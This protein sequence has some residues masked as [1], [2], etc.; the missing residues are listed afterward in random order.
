VAPHLAGGADH[1]N[2]VWAALMFQLWHQIFI[3]AAQPSKPDHD[4]KALTE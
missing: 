3:E 4:L 1:T 2:K